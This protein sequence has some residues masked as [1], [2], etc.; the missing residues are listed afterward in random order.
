[1]LVTR[2]PRLLR[3][4]H[5]TRSFLEPYRMELHVRPILPRSM[6]PLRIY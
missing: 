2:K 5:I 1:M 6:S 3:I 4:E